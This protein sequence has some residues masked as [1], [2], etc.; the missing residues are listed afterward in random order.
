M[1]VSSAESSSP[2]KACRLL[3]IVVVLA[4]A[5]AAHADII[6]VD[7]AGGGDFLTIQEAIDSGAAGDTILVASGTYVGPLNRDLDFHGV[8]LVLQSEDGPENTTI[9]CER[10]GRGFC[11]HSGETL[12]SLISGFAVVNGYADPDT[13]PQ[14]YGCGGA[15]WLHASS[16]RFVDMVFAV[17]STASE[18]VCR[19]GGA[20]YIIGSARRVQVLGSVFENNCAY[21]GGAIYSHDAAVDVEDCVFT[22]NTSVDWGGALCLL[23]GVLT[24]LDSRFARNEGLMGGAIKL[25]GDEDH[26]VS[27][28]VFFGNHALDWGGAISSYASRP[29]MINCLFLQNS[30]EHSGAAIGVSWGANGT[31]D[32]CTFIRNRNI[33]SGGTFSS[34]KASPLIQNCTFAYNAPSPGAG[35]IRAGREASPQVT[36]SVI[37]F[38]EA[39]TAVY[40]D[41]ETANPQ[42]SYSCVFGNAGGDSLC[43]TFNDI[44]FDDPALCDTTGGTFYLQE[45][46]PCVGAAAG[47]GTIG[48]WDVGCPCDDPTGLAES[49]DL[50]EVL[51][52]APN[53]ATGH[54]RIWYQNARHGG[55]LSL[56][57]FTAAG[58]RIT[59][60]RPSDLTRR[61]GF[62]EWDGRGHD[63]TLVA[64][65]VYFYELSDGQRVVRGRFALV[66]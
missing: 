39:G 15:V 2:A 37:A 4:V 38:A 53:P 16:A 8:D 18:D 42:T 33:Q 19:N 51:G 59:E 22:G 34:Y 52:A 24:V 26:L 9:D 46:S 36:D 11:L 44:V 61:S 50:L 47:G 48:A 49:P 41:H 45:C 28:C 1:C 21:R 20:I 63:G 32:G 43:G 17:N 31:A 60:F 54:V 62:L 64:S 30:S 65:G 10:L 23:N 58:R 56:S 29:L 35:V 7:W 27:N 5:C 55:V 3:A 12:A 6:R 40:C 57:L 13:L 25:R 66:R 14:P